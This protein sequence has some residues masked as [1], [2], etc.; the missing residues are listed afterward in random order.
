MESVQKPP[1]GGHL[2]VGASWDDFYGSSSDLVPTLM[3]IFDSMIGNQ[4][5]N[6]S[7]PSPTSDSS[8]APAMTAQPAATNNNHLSSNPQPR[9][10]PVLKIVEPGDPL[11]P[12][13]NG[14]INNNVTR[15]GGVRNGTTTSS[16]RR[17]V[18][19]RSSE[20]APGNAAGGG[21]GTGTIT[22]TASSRCG[23]SSS[24]SSLTSL[25]APTSVHSA[26]SSSSTSST[27]S[28]HLT[29]SFASSS[30]HLTSAE[31]LDDAGGVGVT[32]AAATASTGGAA[33]VGAGSGS[34]SRRARSNA[35]NSDLHHLRHSGDSGD[36]GVSSPGPPSS[37]ASEQ[38]HSGEEEEDDGDD[39][40]SDN[41]SYMDRV[42]ME[43]V[44]S[45]AVYVRDL[46]QVVEGYLYFWRDEGERAPLS[47]EQATALFG[48]V[49][50]IYRFNSQFLTQLQ[51]CGL[52][53][54]EVARCFVRNNSGF[55]IYTDYCTNY[56]RKVS[57]LTDL[58]RNEAASRACRERQTQ[59]QHTLPLGSYL[60]KPVQRILKYHLLL[61]NI[62][63]HC[64]RSQT[65]GYSDIIVALSAMTG[66]AHHINDMKRKHEHAVRVQEVQSLL[67]GWPGEDLTT[68]GELVAEGSFRMYGAK[69]PRHVF[70]LDRMLLIVKRKEDGTLGYKVH[71]MCSNL[72]LIESV[73]GE[74]LSFHVIPFDNPRQQYTLEARNL[75][76]K[77]EWA[78]QLKR[79]ILENYDAVIPHHARQLVLQL[80][81]DQRCNQERPASNNGGQSFERGDYAYSATANAGSNS[82]TSSAVHHVKRHQHS[83]PEYLERRKHSTAGLT[84]KGRSRKG[85]KSS[86]D[87]SSPRESPLIPR[88]LRRSLDSRDRSVSQD[89]SDLDHERK[90]STNSCPTAAETAKNKVR[91]FGAWRRRSEPCRETSLVVDQTEAEPTSTNAATGDGK[92]RDEQPREVSGR[93]EIASPS[94]SRALVVDPEP[95]MQPTC[96][97][98]QLQQ[99]QRM[100]PESLER[101]VEQLVLQN[102][103]IQ[104]ILQRKKRRAAERQP[105]ASSSSLSSSRP[106][107]RSESTT[108]DEG[109][110]DTL[111]SP[112]APGMMDAVEGVLSDIDG[113]YV[114][115]RNVGDGHFSRCHLRRS[116]GNK[117]PE[118][119]VDSSHLAGSGAF[120]SQQQLQ[121]AT[122]SRSLSCPA[123]GQ[124][125]VRVVKKSEASVSES[126]GAGGNRSLAAVGGRIQKLL[127]HIGSPDHWSNWIRSL[128]PPQRRTTTPGEP[129]AS[130]CRSR[131]RRDP[132]DLDVDPMNISTSPC[133]PSVWLQLQS[134]H[135]AEPG[136][137]SGSLP[138]SFQTP[139]DLKSRWMDR[140]ITIASDR[141][142]PIDLQTD[143]LEL[144][145]RSQQERPSDQTDQHSANEGFDDS[146]TD[147]PSTPRVSTDNIHVHPDYKIYRRSASKS[148]LKTVLS[149]VSSKLRSGSEHFWGSLFS[150]S[151][152]D[153][154]VTSPS[155][156]GRQHSKVIHYLANRY[157]LLLRQRHNSLQHNSNPAAAAH[158]AVIGARIANLS[159]SADY[160]IP[161]YS[162][163]TTPSCY[164]TSRSDLSSSKSTV[165]LASK[166]TWY[167][168]LESTRDAAMQMMMMDSDDSGS[169]QED[170]EDSATGMDGFFYERAFEAVE[171]LLDGAAADW[172]C[173][174][175]AIFSDRDETGSVTEAAIVKTKPPPPPV[176]SKSQRVHHQQQHSRH[177]GMAIL[178]RMRSLEE[179]GGVKCSGK[180]VSASASLE[181]LKSISQRRMEL[182]QAFT[183]SGKPGDESETSSQHSTSTVNTVVEVHPAGGG[184]ADDSIDPHSPIHQRRMGATGMIQP[185]MRKGMESPQ[186][187]SESANAVPLPKGW[188]K[189]IIGKLQGDAK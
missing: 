99:P 17:S 151:H 128:S 137:K 62:V 87:G 123:R 30:C 159:D 141:P 180:E 145:I 72:M 122:L 73:P 119:M 149:S 171:Q 68:Y 163:P 106:Y 162:S 113:D 121:K 13:T 170:D 75:E 161:K 157:A 181:N 89:R 15:S 98:Q 74:P 126:S 22:S 127:N 90:F 133:V 144:Y 179:N 189:H 176:A 11:P 77:R 177:R 8:C 47:P 3:D 96:S 34:P 140:P 57:V 143:A 61:Q 23:S 105:S 139:P 135:L 7:P 19:F 124:Q 58:M 10:F 164:S 91:K 160:V 12:L 71:I 107:I 9:H 93:L 53:P 183:S 24:S 153:S 120:P 178:D 103:E 81:Q 40:C 147:I 56:P 109:I 112:S 111:M 41:L 142:A 70:L 78:L 27:S 50:D 36:S 44:E 146:L 63:K 83:A 101:I 67:D 25:A 29:S 118:R 60:L 182:T 95:L 165:S 76:Q 14:P 188:V 184:L 66:I 39:G 55:T 51:S 84:A 125:A 131:S 2:D 18:S 59:L 155:S 82:N 102:V 94:S 114:M 28:G 167:G 49:D 48:N 134:E 26:T 6:M 169:E 20:L 150:L 129:D 104:R 156:A 31:S 154:A 108:L 69:A 33:T 21:A 64:D 42:V 4:Q 116:L 175:S 86:H 45:E 97:P 148:S 136:K 54:V 173:R 152:D 186:T 65:P 132:I 110:Y 37:E 115:I 35:V 100:V 88:R 130:S 43:V 185:Q 32:L 174:D 52:D 85:R 1:R 92:V 46:Q 168:T 158:S 172:C 138:R 166:T 117:T 187:T 38:K 5:H 80:G 16:P 79:V